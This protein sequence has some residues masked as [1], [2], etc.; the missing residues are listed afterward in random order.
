MEEKKY[1][2]MKRYRPD[3]AI[4]IQY[5]WNK[6]YISRICSNEQKTIAYTIRTYKTLSGA[7][8]YMERYDEKY[9]DNANI[10]PE[11]YFGSEKLIKDG[12]YWRA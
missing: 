9:G 8:K 5:C 2:Y 3:Y 12:N 6:Y 1:L 11:L 10:V 7:S 4:I